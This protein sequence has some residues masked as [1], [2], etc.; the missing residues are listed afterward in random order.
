ME[1]KLQTLPQYFKT[2]TSPM[3]QHSA[4][5]P[6]KIEHRYRGVYERAGFDVNLKGDSPT[7]EIR[8]MKS[9][10]MLRFQQHSNGAKSSNSSVHSG[11]GSMKNA[12]LAPGSA[13]TSKSFGELQKRT[14]YPVY[15]NKVHSESEPNTSQFIAKSPSSIKSHE[16]PQIARP[17]NPEI[18]VV[19]IQH[20]DAADNTELPP[21]SNNGFTFMPV[22]TQNKNLKNLSLNLNDSQT[23]K[24]DNSQV[25]ENDNDSTDNESYD[26]TS[27][28]SVNNHYNQIN[29]AGSRR[30]SQSS[31][32]TTE[33]IT[34]ALMQSGYGLPS[35]PPTSKSFELQP[36]DSLIKKQR[37]SSALN[38]FRKDIE[39]HKNYV[40]KTP[41]VPN[42]P[43]F[44]DA[45]QL[46]TTLP[47]NRVLEQT[48]STQNPD[49]RFSYNQNYVN[50]TNDVSST[51]NIS[52]DHTNDPSNQFQNFR[53]QQLAADTQLNDEYQN[54]LQSGGKI[55][56]RAS[57]VSMVSSILSKNSDYERD[58]GAD[59]AMERQ[60]QALKMGENSND[61][62][63][64]ET[65]NV[66]H[67]KT[68][69]SDSIHNSSSYGTVPKRKSK[70]IAAAI[71]TIN[72]QNIDED[73]S[74]VSANNT[75]EN[76]TQDYTWESIK[77]LSVNNS[78]KR[79]LNEDSHRG[80]IENETN[81][82]ASNDGIEVKPLSPKNHLVEEELRNMNFAVQE[83]PTS[84]NENYDNEVEIQD[85]SFKYPSGKGPCRSCRKEISPLSKGSQKAV[86]SKTGELSGQWHRSCFTCAYA[87]CTI[88]FSKSIQCYVYDD[89]AFC[90]NHYHELNDTLCQYCSKG[91]EGECVE[92]ELY[93]KWHLHCLTC[94]QCKSQ[95]NKDYYLINGASYCEEDAVKIIKGGSS[96]EDLSGKVKTGGL[97]TSDKVEKRRTRIMYVE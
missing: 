27:E 60:L 22:S 97:T 81:V 57:Q 51:Q 32:R 36:D 84:G 4:F 20:C 47:P 39:D 73:D 59:E 41:S 40:P 68:A 70:V 79:Q 72:I 76:N 13:K 44:G 26:T 62:T 78:E 58:D 18:P 35:P 95:I 64:N 49:N 77:P 9:P 16:Q 15:E 34:P 43:I 29:D 86:F 69:S 91:I 96:Y 17:V 14:P 46:S 53:D 85:S 75:F 93:Q 80:V 45:P 30:S 3:I 83:V 2:E 28:T 42:T 71:P 50:N 66:H 65:V 92:N 61:N 8:S 12:Y 6:F 55:Q 19:Q 52:L 67:S 90:H 7:S 38:E 88:K 54:F 5:P 33:L 63:I 1:P 56:P 89:N 10:T 74:P 24:S 11:S 37:L 87:G 48:D 31:I 25:N 21:P 82:D 23:D 94:H